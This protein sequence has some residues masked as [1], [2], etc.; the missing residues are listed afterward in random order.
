MNSP[1]NAAPP[2]DELMLSD[3]QQRFFHTFGYLLLRN[4]LGEDTAA[5]SAAFDAVMADPDNGG[6]ALDY[7][8]GD[9][10]MVPA[11]VDRHPVLQ[12]LK[13]DPRIT[14]IPDSLIG[15]DWEYAES[16][17]DVMRCETT[18]HR[19]VY[20]SPLTQFHI[21]LL[22]YLDPLTATTGALRVLPGTNYYQ[23]PYV[24]DVLAGQ[25]FPDRME[26]VFGIEAEQL[27][28]VPVETQPGDI[29]VLNFR[30]VHGSFRGAS[31]RRLMNMNYKEPG[32]STAS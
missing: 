9:R 13:S 16:S 25:G 28:A 14:A 20:H 17:G 22:F 19:D 7:A 1:D 5:I 8:S 2:P 21:K 31:T 4:R 6:I 24:K 12:R 27:P 18:W 15:A 10:L 3:T 23:D 32:S 29:V 26:E 11:L 30:T